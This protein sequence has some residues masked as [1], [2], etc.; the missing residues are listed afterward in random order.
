MPELDRFLE[1]RDFLL[2][3]RG[4]YEAAIEGFRW[5]EFSNFNWA[6]D[7]FDVIADGNDEPALVIVEPSGET[8]RRSYAE[9]SSRSNQVAN[10]LASCGVAKGD[11]VLVMLGNELALWETVLALIKLGAVMI[12]TTPLL[13][14][15]DLADRL[16]RSGVRLAVSN[17]AGAP[18]IEAL[19][20]TES[21]LV[22]VS[23]GDPREGW[24]ALDDAA[25]HADTFAPAA[26]TS[27][28]DPLIEY[29]TSGTTTRPKL[30]R[31][32]QAS[33]SVGHLSTMFWLGLKRGDVHWTI[34]SPGW[35]K[36]AWS[37]FFTPF[38]CTGVRLCLQLHAL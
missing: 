32:T 9:L 14:E 5:P 26:P 10:F 23:V 34:S 29:F 19:A 15:A 18:A 8:V 27:A 1:A 25:G 20:A 11:R 37:C 33:Y 35:A 28:D 7:Y 38:K 22:R 12:P 31:H 24:I 4:N 3:T 21:S 30:V 16:E 13:A 6:L 36:H 17:E 2:S